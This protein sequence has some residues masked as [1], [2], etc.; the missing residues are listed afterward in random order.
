MDGH[1]HLLRSLAQLRCEGLPEARH[2]G[3]D[4]VL[5][6]G[7]PGKPVRI[8]KEVAF[9][10]G[11]VQ[12]QGLDKL[13]V[14]RQPEKLIRIGQSLLPQQ[15]GDLKEGVAFRNCDRM[16]DH[17]AVPDSREDLGGAHCGMKLI[18]SCQYAP[19]GGGDLSQ[20]QEATTVPDQ[21]RLFQQDGDLP[22]RRAFWN[23]N[24]AGRWLGGRA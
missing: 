5:R 6:L 11:D 24:D 1:V 12:V 19:I 2:H 3:G 15:L 14:T 9:Q 18:L 10:R 22:Q 23:K 13:L 4:D 8:R 20:G 7:I 17:L 16:E 21:A